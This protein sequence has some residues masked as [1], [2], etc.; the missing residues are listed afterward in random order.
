MITRL[1]KKLYIVSRVDNK[2]IN[3]ILVQTLRKLT[4]TLK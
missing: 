1:L 4:E 3:G 2:E